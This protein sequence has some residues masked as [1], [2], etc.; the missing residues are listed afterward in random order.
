MYSGRLVALLIVTRLQSQVPDR[1]LPIG[2]ERVTLGVS[3][4]H[5]QPHPP[6][7][8]V[9]DL[10]GDLQKARNLPDSPPNLR[11]ASRNGSRFFRSAIRS[12]SIEVEHLEQRLLLARLIV[13][14]TAIIV[15]MM[16]IAM[17]VI[18]PVLIR[19]VCPIITMTSVLMRAPAIAPMDRW[20]RSASHV[21]RALDQLVQLATIEPHATT[22]R[23]VINLHSLT[24]RHQ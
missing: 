1:Y 4:F 21:V 24:L 6:E 2:G 13:M 10:S 16:G 3:L 9:V 18:L 14:A 5:S 8:Q 23:A 19:S 17:R 15:A 7:W 11:T 12:L 20:H 22:T